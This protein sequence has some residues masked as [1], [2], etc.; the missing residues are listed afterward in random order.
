MLEKKTQLNY[1]HM[2]KFP[3]KAELFVWPKHINISINIPGHMCAYMHT[4]GYVKIH[5]LGHQLAIISFED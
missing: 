1:I 3:Q 4:Y 2:N 5:I